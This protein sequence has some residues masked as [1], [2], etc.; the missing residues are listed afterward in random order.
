MFWLACQTLTGQSQNTI[1]ATNTH[2]SSCLHCHLALVFVYVTPAITNGMR[3]WFH[4]GD[5]AVRVTVVMSAHHTWFYN[6]YIVNTYTRNKI[7]LLINMVGVQWW[8]AVVQ[9]QVEFKD[10][11]VTL[12]A[13]CIRWPSVL[14]EYKLKRQS[15]LPVYTVCLWPTSIQNFTR[16][17]SMVP[18]RQ[19]GAK[20]RFQADTMSLYKHKNF[21]NPTLSG[22]TTLTPRKYVLPTHL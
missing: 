13:S 4:P 11:R 5:F 12:Y 6:I 17:A 10:L 16:L 8:I 21:F 20:Y 19:S 2:T 9:N 3:C 7:Q 14:D 1:Y 15:C 22:T 18:H